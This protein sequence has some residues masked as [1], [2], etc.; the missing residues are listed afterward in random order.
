MGR[1]LPL[2]GQKGGSSGGDGQ[3]GDTMML[4]KEEEGRVCWWGLMLM[5][6]GSITTRNTAFCQGQNPCQKDKIPGKRDI[7]EG[8]NEGQLAWQR[9]SSQTLC[10]G[11]HPWQKNE[12]LN[13]WE[14]ATLSPWQNPWH[15]PSLSSCTSD[16]D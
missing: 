13:P 4:V 1:V 15:V 10:Q 9:R 14:K 6:L 11:L 12:G 3:K 2:C 8:K 16:Y 5:I 7:C